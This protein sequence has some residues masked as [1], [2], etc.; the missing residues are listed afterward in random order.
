MSETIKIVLC[1]ILP[2]IGTTVGSGLVF[3]LKG[4]MPDRL[5]KAL[6]GVAAVVMI[7]A[8]VFRAGDP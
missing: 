2:L 4:A 5:Q 6:L 7:A 1:I 3:F 8:A